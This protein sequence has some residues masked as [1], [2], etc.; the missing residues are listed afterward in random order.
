MTVSRFFA[1]P[2]RKPVVLT[3][4]IGN[5]ALRGAIFG[6][7]GV[8]RLRRLRP[9]G[10]P[11]AGVTD[12]SRALLGQLA[13]DARANGMEPVAIG[14]ASAGAH[15]L[16]ATMLSSELGLPVGFSHSVAA[17]GFAE[18]FAGPSEEQGNTVFVTVGTRV[19]A[20]IVSGGYLLT[21]CT[22]SA[23]KLGHL[24]VMP[25]GE[26]CHCGQQ[27]CLE[28]YFSGEGLVRRYRAFGGP[29]TV[30]GADIARL[31][32]DDLLCG[33]LWNDGLRALS[34]GL[35]AITLL[36]DPAA[37]ILGGN[38]PQPAPNLKEA[39]GSRLADLLASR[40]APPIRASRLGNG[41]A[42]I[43]AAILAFQMAGHVGIASTWD[44]ASA[45]HDPAF[46]RTS[47]EY[48]SWNEDE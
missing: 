16:L 22:D 23:G 17:R 38:L 28:V 11:G 47:A 14:I 42:Q 15:P 30:A 35:A 46:T 8:A 27:G 18:S 10:P 31:Q 2:E 44:L 45:S 4:E 20:A 25:D 43:G 19:R 37:I 7:D 34:L 9:S 32:N 24:P 33:L 12:R 36:V 26:W 5:L 41:A 13:V 40:T 39:I 6:M 29:L 1:R 48:H 3:V 21:G